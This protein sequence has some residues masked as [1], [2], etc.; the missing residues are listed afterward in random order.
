[1]NDRL[2]QLTKLAESAPSLKLHAG[3]FPNST[4]TGLN[5]RLDLLRRV[6]ST[7]VWR[8]IS[9]L[10][11]LSDEER[12]RVFDLCAE[13]GYQNAMTSAGNVPLRPTFAER[14]PLPQNRLFN[15]IF[16]VTR[17]SAFPDRFMR[18][19]AAMPDVLLDLDDESRIP[20]IVAAE[21][22]VVANAGSFRNVLHARLKHEFG[23]ETSN[24]GGGE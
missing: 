16:L 1:M 22:P 19:S 6:P 15:E 21:T 14:N 13:I 8:T 17:F 4:R 12:S 23:V 20:A 24:H 18:Q 11:K 7:T 3:H 10:Q 2:S 5:Q 9:S